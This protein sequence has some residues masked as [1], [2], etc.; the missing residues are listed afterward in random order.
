MNIRKC[1]QLP[2]LELLSQKQEN[3]SIILT[4]M[5]IE[6]EYRYEKKFSS[7]RLTQVSNMYL[8]ATKLFLAGAVSKSSSAKKT[9]E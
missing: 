5:L 2:R 7:T 1:H 8:V 9:N 4:K 3:M 6:L